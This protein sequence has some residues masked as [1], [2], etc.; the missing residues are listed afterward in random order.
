MKLELVG[1]RPYVIRMELPSSLEDDVSTRTN[2]PMVEIDVDKSD[3]AS[4]EQYVSEQIDGIV[5]VTPNMNIE[6]NETT[7]AGLP[8]YAVEVTSPGGPGKGFIIYTMTDYGTVYEIHYTS[9]TSK[10][11][12]YFPIIQ[13]IMNSFR[14]V[15]SG[16]VEGG[17]GGE[18][19]GD[20]EDQEIEE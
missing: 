5:S 14:I 13:K 10:F 11:D 18:E 17:Q 9:H 12:T 3:S 4:L 7:L 15:D 1:G 16:A 8:A 20:G 2:R 19:Q 6:S